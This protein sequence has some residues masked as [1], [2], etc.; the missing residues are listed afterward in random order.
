MRA[1]LRRTA[2]AAA[3]GA[4][5][6]SVVVAAGTATAVAAPSPAR[7][8][9]PSTRFY[10]PPP[11]QAAFD[12]VRQLAEE[13]Q[14]GEALMVA[15]MVE[16]PQAVWFDGGTPDQVRSQVRKTMRAAAR[17]RAVPVLVAYDIPGRDCSQYSA[18]GAADE[19][20]YEQWI[21]A[22]AQGIGRQKAVVILEPDS[23]ANLP[24]DCAVYGSANYPYTDA[25][26]YA[27]IQDAVSVL[28]TQPRASVYL[29]AGQSAWQSVGTMTQTLVTAGVAKA[30]GFFLNV[31]NYQP[32]V[33]EDA[34]G[35]W[36]SDCI[37]MTTDD[38][39]GNYMYGNPGYC[40]SQYYP[41]QQDNNVSWQ[42][43]YATWPQVSAWY[44]K[45]MSS[46]G[47]G[48]ATVPFV[49][50]T[51]RNGQGPNDMQS[52]A[53]SPYDQPPADVSTLVNGNWCNPP[54][55]G[56]GLTPTADT[57]QPLV[58]AY[59]W[60]KTPG[61]SDGQCDS[62]GGARAWDYSDYTQ[63]GWPTTA[64]AQSTFDPLWGTV[65]PAAGAWFPQQALQLAEDADGSLSA[66]QNQ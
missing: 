52:Y 36:I 54:G 20:A 31:S 47:V 2:S 12:Q 56:L 46:L 34:Y 28:E 38:I 14:P 53:A 4:L 29:D 43:N 8:L 24:S 40:Q 59:L 11:S 51:S 66:P 35:T 30:Q 10:V 3:A 9:A 26:R 42:T 27:E 63:P 61:Q 45:T 21:A 41:A 5:L 25:E 55:V 15:R 13:G 16:T 48:P 64:S 60:V 65:D 18:G 33:E 6:G 57:D 50:D 23:L 62:A 22:F 44:A 49:V 58:N 39:A 19:A 7:A 32:T 37:D 17:Q 1:M